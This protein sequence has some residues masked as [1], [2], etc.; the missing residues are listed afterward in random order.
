MMSRPEETGF[1]YWDGHTMNFASYGD[2]GL[3]VRNR[4][5]VDLGFHQT[6]VT[7]RYGTFD[8]HRK[9]WIH[10]PLEHFP[11]EFRMHLLLKGIP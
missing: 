2:P 5:I 4:F 6:D 8:S 7:N 1:Y 9:Q 3:M 10:I 11:P